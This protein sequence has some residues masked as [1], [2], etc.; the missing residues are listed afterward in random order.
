MRWPDARELDWEMDP[1]EVLSRF[2]VDRRVALLHSGRY[3]PRWS[4][5]SILA[6]PA[7]SFRFDADGTSRWIG[8]AAPLVSF[9][10]R[11]FA[12]LRAL[13]RAAP[14]WLFVGFFGYDLGR[15]IEPLPARA[16][17]DRGWP[18]IELGAAP[19]YLVHDRA[20]ARWYACGT[21]A[22]E[23]PPELG[24]PL[25]ADRWR[26]REP[27]SVFT[28]DGYLAAVASAKERIAAG[29]I[30]QVNLAQRFTARFE[31][32]PAAGPRGL[33]ARLATVSPAWYG[34]YVELAPEANGA[35]G[36]A[37]A[38]TSPELF[39]HVD[40]QRVI[41][42]PIKGTA[43]S[44]D[45]VEAL[46]ASV[47]DTAELHMIVDLL[48]N[49][50]GRVCDFGSVRV[51]E[52]R[53]IETHPTVHH[54]VATVEGRLHPKNDI[55]RLLRA[56]FPGGSVTGAPKIRAMEIIDE[57]EPVRRGPYC[58]SIGCLTRDWAE[59]NV[60]IRTMLLDPARRR[61]DYSVGGGI[62][63]DSDP[64]SEHAETLDKAQ[65]ILRT[66]GEGERA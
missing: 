42:R 49:D 41:T 16:A 21:W 11:P 33:F 5:F 22:R 55:P 32:E 53:V 47:K 25:P 3:E 51:P 2:P 52:P 30:F 34:A 60:A 14:D 17:D 31:A 19:G 39:L 12:D 48:R 18:A 45:S 43:A 35:S 27:A 26:A 6:S 44:S 64:E 59:L 40:G 58:G 62:V 10:H 13:L 28:R 65:A 46:R 4:R 8:D 36:R 54:G 66:L 9:E 23:G 61:L 57:L 29:D 15:W 1:L 7:A 24:P 20:S 56:A 38:S 63:A 37:L 50:L